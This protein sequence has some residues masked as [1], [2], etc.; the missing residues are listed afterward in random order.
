MSKPVSTLV[1]IINSF[2]K[3]PV[4]VYGVPSVKSSTSPLAPNASTILPVV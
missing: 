4:G 2:Q 1:S 3:F